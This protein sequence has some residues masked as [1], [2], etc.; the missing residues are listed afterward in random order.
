MSSVL[1]ATVLCVLSVL[2]LLFQVRREIQTLLFYFDQRQEPRYINF[3]AIKYIKIFFTVYTFCLIFISFTIFFYNFKVLTFKFL[4]NLEKTLYMIPSR[5]SDSLIYFSHSK[6][7]Y[8]LLSI[9]WSLISLLICKASSTINQSLWFWN[10]YVAELVYFFS[11]WY[12]WY[13]LNI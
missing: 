3:N 6:L 11:Y 9:E 10:F 2:L 12:F 4:L 8:S 7:V 13:V 5:K 1:S